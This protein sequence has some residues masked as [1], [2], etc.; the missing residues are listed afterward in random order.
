MS[1][2]T[3]TQTN[4]TALLAEQNGR[5][6]FERVGT[7]TTVQGEF[8]FVRAVNGNVEFGADTEVANG[9]APSDGDTLQQGETLWAPFTKIDI[10]TG[11]VLYAYYSSTHVS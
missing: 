1:T 7:A 10:D 11:G 4:K 2:T 5:Y 9:T 8:A 6:G 3:P